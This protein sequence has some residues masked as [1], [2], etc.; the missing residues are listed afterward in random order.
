MAKIILKFDYHFIFWILFVSLHPSN[1]RLYMM[2]QD[3]DWKQMVKCFSERTMQ[4]LQIREGL[5]DRCFRRLLM[6][7]LAYSLC[8]AFHKYLLMRSLGEFSTNAPSS[9]QEAE[10]YVDMLNQWC[11]IDLSISDYYSTAR[12][13]TDMSILFY[14][15]YKEL[16][17]ILKSSRYRLDLSEHLFEELYEECH[18]IPLIEVMFLYYSSICRTLYSYM[19]NHLSYQE[20]MDRIMNLKFFENQRTMDCIMLKEMIAT[21]HKWIKRYGELAEEKLDVQETGT[22]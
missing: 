22:K 14:R 16:Q 6:L 18:Q 20:C 1:K 4:R 13:S 10:K 21:G 19:C 2:T 17:E 15:N 7:E 11:G 9:V 3:S 8:M 5:S 12:S